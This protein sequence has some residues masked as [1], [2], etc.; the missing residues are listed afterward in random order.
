MIEY[1]CE[2]CNRNLEIPKKTKKAQ[3]INCEHFLITP[4][5]SQEEIQKREKIRRNYCSKCDRDQYGVLLEVMRNDSLLKIKNRKINYFF[6]YCSL[7]W[8]IIFIAGLI[9]ASPYSVGTYNTIDQYYTTLIILISF[10]GFSSLI[11]LFF[12]KKRNKIKKEIEKVNSSVSKLNS[13]GYELVCSIC[14]E[15]LVLKKPIEND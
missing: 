8:V 7:I 12:Y 2:F 14:L 13:D 4:S 9:G 3:C 6:F 10:I 5:L 11:S 1:Y 15:P